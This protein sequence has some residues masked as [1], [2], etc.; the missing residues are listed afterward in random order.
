M[1]LEEANVKLND[2][3]EKALAGESIASEE[4]LRS[5]PEDDLRVRFNLGWHDMR[6]GHLKKGLE[7]MNAGRFIEVFGSPKIQGSIW[8]DEPLEGKVL[9]FRCEGGLGDEIINFR[10]ASEF[11]NKGAIVVVSGHPS[12]L[13]IFARHGFACVTTA[14]VEKGEVYYDYWMPAM[15]AAGVLGYEFD[16]LP[17]DAY[18][19]AT[20]A[21][22]QATK[23]LKVGI[24]W[25]GNPQFEHEQHRRFDPQPLI[26][27]HKIPGVELYSF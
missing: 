23:K 5:C 1:I 26:D 3:L 9:L 11:K 13:P 27:L 15:S 6:N 24:R 4:L 8:R 16:T 21:P 2:A 18:L 20:P 14:A 25:S 17:G 19:T 10:F 12:L 7:G 22:L